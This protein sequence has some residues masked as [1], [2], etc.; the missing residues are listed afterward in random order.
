METIFNFLLA[1]ALTMVG[2]A[3]GLFVFLLAGSLLSQRETSDKVKDLESEYSMRYIG[4]NSR[5]VNLLHFIGS[6]DLPSGGYSVGKQ[7]LWNYYFKAKAEHEAM[8]K[9]EHEHVLAVMFNEPVQTDKPLPETDTTAAE[10]W[11]L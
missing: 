4:R 8:T 1:I 11:V 7:A 5:L 2:V 6:P 3:L 9:L 10:G